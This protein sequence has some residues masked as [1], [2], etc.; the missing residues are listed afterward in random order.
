LKNIHLPGKLI[1]PNKIFFK[2]G[3]E[4]FNSLYNFSSLLI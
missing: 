2:N 4:T 3:L 1:N